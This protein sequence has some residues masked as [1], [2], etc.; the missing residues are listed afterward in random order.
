MN[1]WLSYERKKIVLFNVT[2]WHAAKTREILHHV[3]GLRMQLR[4]VV[5]ISPCSILVRERR[6]GKEAPRSC[7]LRM[8]TMSQCAF[9]PPTLS[10]SSGR[11]IFRW[12]TRIPSNPVSSWIDQNDDWLRL[13]HA[14]LARVEK[15]ATG[16]DPC[17]CTLL[18]STTDNAD[19]EPS[20]LLN[21]LH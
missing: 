1:G 9:D 14:P 2:Q 13:M 5:T 15:Q 11:Q 16:I 21:S 6:F 20:V 19:S 12:K 3:P 8:T 18:P 4:V 17:R 7:C 10:C